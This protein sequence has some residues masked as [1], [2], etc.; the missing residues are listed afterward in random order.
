[1]N[2]A[3]YFENVKNAMCLEHWGVAKVWQDMSLWFGVTIWDVVT[4]QKCSHSYPPK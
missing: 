3:M 4:T 1:M 2:V